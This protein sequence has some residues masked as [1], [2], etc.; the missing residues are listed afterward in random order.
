VRKN[1]CPL[2]CGGDYV[3]I[4]LVYD[5]NVTEKTGQR[6]LQKTFKIC[7]KFLNHIQNSTFEG[8]LSE[9]QILKLK[10]EMKNII[11][12]DK[13]SVIIFIS[14]NKRW[15]KKEFWGIRVDTTASFI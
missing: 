11:R 5:I 4:I 10:Y 1:T 13:D 9:S 8:E 3:Y 2:R 6:I 7:K 15:L 14:R 12:K